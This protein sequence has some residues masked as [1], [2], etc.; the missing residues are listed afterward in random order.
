MS[1]APSAA[2]ASSSTASTLGDTG[3][4][5]PGHGASTPGPRLGRQ[6][7]GRDLDGDVWSG[8][9]WLSFD[10]S[11]VS[12]S[13]CAWRGFGPRHVEER[14]LLL[15]LRRHRGKHQVSAAMALG[16][17]TQSDMCQDGCERL[18]LRQAPGDARSLAGAGDWT[19]VIRVD[20]SAP[21]DPHQEPQEEPLA[22]V[23]RLG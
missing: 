17:P 4:S 3:A 6:K 13:L 19:S 5:T 16:L 8:T 15:G 7:A 22:S 9:V 12:G 21:E 1:L 2:V 18:L 10:G 11:L 23:H 20:R 14:R